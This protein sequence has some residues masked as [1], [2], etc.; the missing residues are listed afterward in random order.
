M[1]PFGRPLFENK[2]EL[3]R[4]NSILPLKEIIYRF[5]RPL[6]ANQEKLLNKIYLEFFKIRIFFQA[7]F[8]FLL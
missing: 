1:N 6:F 4:L 8:V 3:V 2:K 7:A 5:E